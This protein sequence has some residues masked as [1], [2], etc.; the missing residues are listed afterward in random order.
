[1]NTIYEVVR[2][3][4]EIKMTELP[5]MKIQSPSDA[6]ALVN[7]YI[8]DEDREIMLVVVLNTQNDV[9]AIHRCHMGTLNAS[10]ASTRDV[11][12]TALMNNA[13]ALILAH[14]HP[15]GE[16]RPS[17][18]DCKLTNL[19]V[20]AGQLLQIEILDHVIVGWKEGYYSFKENA[21]I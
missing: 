21:L 10:L 20:E 18:E 14:N 19:M 3:K 11:F 13:A 7:E 9:T 12:K 4:Q 1:M 16:V 8:L 17:Q 15:S 6:V 2:V 5:L